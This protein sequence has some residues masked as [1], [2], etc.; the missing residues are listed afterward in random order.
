MDGAMGFSPILVVTKLNEYHDDDEDLNFDF[1]FNVDFD[2][3]SRIIPEDRP[4]PNEDQTVQLTSP[5]ETPIPQE[6][7][8]HAVLPPNGPEYEQARSALEY[9]EKE[10]AWD[11]Y[12]FQKVNL[13]LMQRKEESV[14]AASGVLAT[15]IAKSIDER[16][17]RCH[18][19]YCLKSWIEGTIDAEVALL[20]LDEDYG[21]RTQ[22]CENLI[23][24]L[25]RILTEQ[26]INQ[27]RNKEAPELDFTV[28]DGLLQRSETPK[29]TF[30]ALKE[31]SDDDSQP[32]PMPEWL[33]DLMIS[34]ST[35]AKD[36]AI[37]IQKAEKNWTQDSMYKT[38]KLATTQS[39]YT[40]YHPKECH[41]H[42]VLFEVRRGIHHEQ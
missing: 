17:S 22:A 39:P 41:V 38:L 31:R 21:H 37:S 32:E 20:A 5:V 29:R 10:L 8:R 12:H 6:P 34:Y 19:L 14:R 28:L 25:A 4:S 3:I 2:R 23:Q 13:E 33:N 27:V 36:L 7:E 42:A 18:D 35:E 11:L 1:P 24:R 30:E 40:P 16:L 15:A 9:N 26:E